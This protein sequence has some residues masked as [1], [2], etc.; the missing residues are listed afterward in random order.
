MSE[1]QPEKNQDKNV[2][3]KRIAVILVRGLVNVSG[4][5]K[6][7][8]AMLRLVRKNHCVIL[9]DT[10]ENKGMV[11]KV[12]DYVTWGILDN[13][14]FKELVTKRGQEY[15]GRTTDSKKRYSYKTL[16]VDSK[17]YR[18]YFRLNPPQ[19][20][21]GRKGIKVSFSAGGALGNRE[22]KINNLIKRML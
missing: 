15:R 21:F 8:L 5:I 3:E 17:K 4:D 14:T 11:I 20:G 19:K 10:P 18:P 7:T 16:D 2:A 1:Q 12:K 9:R 13:A 6:S 22:D